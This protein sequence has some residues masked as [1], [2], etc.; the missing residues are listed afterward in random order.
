MD[1]S[2]KL[3]NRFIDPQAMLTTST[4]SR[5]ALN[6]AISYFRRNFL[7]T[8]RIKKA[9]KDAGIGVDERNEILTDDIFEQRISLARAY[10]YV[11]RMIPSSRAGEL[12]SVLQGLGS[13]TSSES[14]MPGGAAK[15]S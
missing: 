3:T 7:T 13:V 2:S 15:K 10:E 14:K 6:A 9:F 12:N 4:I 1:T 5:V 11:V 8:T